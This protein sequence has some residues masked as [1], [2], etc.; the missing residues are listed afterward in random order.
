[1]LALTLRWRLN[2]TTRRKLYRASDAARMRCYWRKEFE[3]IFNRLETRLTLM[4]NVLE[5]N[6]QSVR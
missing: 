3:A 1:M 4:I 6:D 2:S 5:K